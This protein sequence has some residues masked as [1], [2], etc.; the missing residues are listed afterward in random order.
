MD[1]NE[2][3]SQLNLNLPDGEY[4]TI[5]GFVLS[6]LGEIP[7]TGD[8]F[9]FKDLTFEII[10]MDQLRIDSILITINPTDNSESENDSNIN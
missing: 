2:V 8:K 7:D 3:N 5:A 9:T 1:I 6:T 10:N 4:E